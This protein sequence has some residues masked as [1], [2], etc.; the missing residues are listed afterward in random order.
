MFSWQSRLKKLRSIHEF[1]SPDEHHFARLI[2]TFGDHPESTACFALRRRDTG[3]LAGVFLFFSDI[4]GQSWHAHS[5]LVDEHV[6]KDFGT[7][8][9]F[10]QAIHFFGDKEVWFGGAPSGANGDGVFTFKKKFA[11]SSRHAHIL[12]VDL[13]EAELTKI[14]Q[15]C[16]TSSWLPNYRNAM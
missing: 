8:L 9:L 15:T 16:M 1:S 5:F 11:N 13:H 3:T 14:R 4:G 10:D 2:T 12:C 6:M 7:Y